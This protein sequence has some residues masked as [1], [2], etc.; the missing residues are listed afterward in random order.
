MNGA[1]PDHWGWC[2]PSWRSR[3]GAIDQQRQLPNATVPPPQASQLPASTVDQAQAIAT[4]SPIL[5]ALGEKEKQPAQEAAPEKEGWWGR[6]HGRWHSTPAASGA[7]DKEMDNLTKL[8][9]ALKKDK[10]VVAMLEQLQQ[11]EA[12]S[13]SPL[14]R[15]D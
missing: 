1:A 6:R 8:V 13:L 15:L 11:N 4:A 2:G 5:T 3:A 10:K 14:S 12:V 9:D 7:N